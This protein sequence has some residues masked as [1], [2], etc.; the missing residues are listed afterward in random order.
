M[1]LIMIENG[2]VFFYADWKAVLAVFVFQIILTI[3]IKK[4]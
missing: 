2:D 3:Y 4:L 1:V